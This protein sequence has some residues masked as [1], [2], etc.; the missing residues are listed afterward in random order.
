MSDKS[1]SKRTSFFST[2]LR[3]RRSVRVV[4][5]DITDLE[6]SGRGQNFQQI[7]STGAVAWGDA[8]HR[9]DSESADKS[10]C[11]VASGYVVRKTEH[12]TTRTYY[13][14]PASW[15]KNG[16]RA[17]SAPGWRKY[18]GLQMQGTGS[19]YFSAQTLL[20]PLQLEIIIC[21]QLG[22]GPCAPIIHTPSCSSSSPVLCRSLSGLLLSLYSCIRLCYSHLSSTNTSPQSPTCIAH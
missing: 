16:Q 10:L 13:P 4:S 3:Y 22:V 6:A 2:T 19:Q 15:V 14:T 11:T 7:T 18:P 12:S 21:S 9:R 5:P 8:G 20:S 1:G 17:G